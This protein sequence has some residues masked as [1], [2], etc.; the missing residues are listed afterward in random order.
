MGRVGGFVTAAIVACSLACAEVAQAAPITV[1]TTSDTSTASTCALRDAIASANSNAQAPG[2]HCQAGSGADTITFGASVTPQ[3]ILNNALPVIQS[4]VTIQGPGSTHLDIHRSNAAPNFGILEVDT[5]TAAISGLKVSNG[6]TTGNGGG[7]DIVFPAI[8]SLDDV[9]VNNNAAV[10]GG[11]IAATGTLSI[12]NSFVTNNAAG[13]A[14]PTPSVSGGGL[15]SNTALT[16]D[17]TTISN[18]QATATS[19]GT[20]ASA[21]GGGIVLGGSVAQTVDRSTIADNTATATG[22]SSFARAEGAGIEGGPSLTVRR[23]TISGNAA[24]A[25][26]NT[27][28]NVARGGALDLENSGTYAIDRVT[29]TG[30]SVSVSGTDPIA[31]GGGIFAVLAPNSANATITS[32]T[33]TANSAS[34]AV[35]ANAEGGTYKNT[36]ISAPQPS[37]ASS[38]VTALST[39]AGYNIDSGTS[40]AFTQPTDHQ[41]TDPMF[42]PAGLTDNGGPTETIQILGTSPAIDQGVSSPGELTDQRE[43]SRPSDFGA[44]ANAPGGDGT[45]IGAFE[46]QDVT[47]PDTSITSGPDEGS[48]ITTRTPGFAFTATEPGSTFECDFDGGGFVACPTP[49]TALSLADGSHTLSVRATDPAHNTDQSPAARAFTVDATG[50][51]MTITSGPAPGSVSGKNVTTFEFTSDDPGATA[52]CAVDGG[53]FGSCSSATSDTIGPLA[54]GVHEFQVRGTDVLLNAGDEVARSFV[55]DTKPPDTTIDKKPKKHTRSAHA[56]FTFSSDEQ[57]VTFQCSV[58]IAPFEPCQSPV[59]LKHLKHGSHRF[60]V[61]AT[62]A[63]GNVDGSPAHDRWRIKR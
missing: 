51:V 52:E 44:I 6:N 30:N 60:R 7:I 63:A 54:D 16:I 39:S 32:S 11:G 4:N 20:I 21:L 42:A 37:G 22:G 18:N 14:G 26:G 47:P 61:E 12:D 36:I 2:S 34:S 1:D 55:V 38:C 49:Y 29:I 10:N 31:L 17:H 8:A 5:G 35:A 40:C 53:A 13:A 59:A 24:S 25:T 9:R 15:F 48:T 62:D 19:T 46:R 56:R 57:G 41:S 28:S 23:S 33:I 58:G 27:T 50:P 43:R 45:D 3:I